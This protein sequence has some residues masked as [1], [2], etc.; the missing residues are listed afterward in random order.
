M[1][2]IRP[3]IILEEEPEN[4]N[5]SEDLIEKVKILKEKRDEEERKLVKEKRLQLLMFVSK[6]FIL[7]YKI[8]LYC[9]IMHLYFRQNSDE[10][11]FNAITN[12]RKEIDIMNYKIIQEKEREIKEQNI[13]RRELAKYKNLEITSKQ[14][15]NV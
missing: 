11:R 12:R 14:V 9:Y 6:K 3:Q 10:I 15:K 7:D 8:K 1:C 13:K 2:I 5:T 4:L